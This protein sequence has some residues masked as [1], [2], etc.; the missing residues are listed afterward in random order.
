MEP[1]FI[2]K[3]DR[4]LRYGSSLFED[5]IDIAVRQNFDSL[6]HY[7][8]SLSKINKKHIPLLFT[9]YQNHVNRYFSSPELRQILSLS[10][11]FLG[12]T[13]HKTNGVYTLLSHTEFVNNGY[14][15]VHGGMYKIIEGLIIELKKENVNIIYNSEIVN[16]QR[17]NK[18]VIAVIDKKGKRYEADQFVINVDPLIFRNKI[19]HKRK[20]ME[21]I[22]ERKHWSMGMLTIYVGI[23]IKLRN[24]AVHNYYIGKESNYHE[25]N[26]F[27][28]YNLPNTPYYYVN[29]QSRYNPDAAPEGCDALMF[30]VPVPNLI[31]KKDWSD[32]DDIV[33]NI[34]KD[35]SNRIGMN[36]K[37]HIKTLK[38]FTPVEWQKKFNLFCGAAL[39]LSHSMDQTGYLRPSN[40]DK[41]FKNLFYTGCSTV[42]GIGL[43][44]D[45]ISSRLTTERVIGEKITPIYE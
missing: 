33:S 40:M 37:S 25:M 24:L 22:I 4:Y 19:L 32:K 2:S 41:E 8:K 6:K 5:T 17:S 35:F 34:I 42:P 11:Y 15:Y 30:V 1:N 7:V 31:Y 14:H 20:Y 10:A 45:I 36:I 29:I 23:D 38:V 44:M 26:N 12:N 9:S 43:P 3:M 27:K 18:T 13:P 39:G 28:H 21:K 16:V